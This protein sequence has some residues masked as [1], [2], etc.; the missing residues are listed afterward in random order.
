MSSDHFCPITSRLRA[1]EQREPARE[2]DEQGPTSGDHFQSLGLANR[3]AHAIFDRQTDQI[4]FPIPSFW[5]VR[6]IGARQAEI[7]VLETLGFC[8]IRDILESD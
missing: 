3:A 5:Q 1:I 2:I 7:G 8:A 4:I 6:K